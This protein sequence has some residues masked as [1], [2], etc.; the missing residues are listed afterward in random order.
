MSNENGMEADDFRERINRYPAP[1]MKLQY[2]ENYFSKYD[3][4]MMTFRPNQSDHV[5]IQLLSDDEFRSVISIM[6]IDVKSDLV[7]QLMEFFHKT[8]PLIKEYEKN[9]LDVCS[10]VQSTTDQTITVNDESLPVNDG[11]VVVVAD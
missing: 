9:S 2:A 6:T 1:T 7:E 10:R 4:E 3:Y 11:Q 5:L 8:V